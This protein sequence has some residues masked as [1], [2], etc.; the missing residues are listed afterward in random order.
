[1]GW[2]VDAAF[3]PVA[4]HVHYFQSKTFQYAMPMREGK[5]ENLYPSEHE[6]DDC[7]RDDEGDRLF[8]HDILHCLGTEAK[9]A[10]LTG[11]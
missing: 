4:F 7:N 9:P 8:R 6:G 5:I 2:N 1:M 11:T 10:K 3:S